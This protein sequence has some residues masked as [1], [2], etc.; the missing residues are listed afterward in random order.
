MAQDVINAAAA[1]AA[2][3]LVRNA[4]LWPMTA[5][6][7]VGKSTSEKISAFCDLANDLGIKLTASQL[8]TLDAL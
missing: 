7:A 6:R 4:M 5:F 8:K 3:E 1:A 2:E